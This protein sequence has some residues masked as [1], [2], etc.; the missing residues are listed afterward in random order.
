MNLLATE[1]VKPDLTLIFDITVEEGFKRIEDR[2]KDRMENKGFE[3]HKKL[4]KG[5]LDIAKKESNRVVVIDA[6]NSIEEVF[7]NIWKILKGR[8]IL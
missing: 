3:F 7:S 5:Y 4:R 2:G 1:G 6:S 8:K